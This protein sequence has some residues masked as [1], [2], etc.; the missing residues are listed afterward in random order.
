L[1]GGNNQPPSKVSSLE[2]AR[3]KNGCKKTHTQSQP[4]PTKKFQKI[5][6]NSFQPTNNIMKAATLVFLVAAAAAVLTVPAHARRLAGIGLKSAPGPAYGVF[7]GAIVP[8]P[9]Q[10]LSP[11]EVK[12]VACGNPS[13]AFLFVVLCFVCGGGMGKV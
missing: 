6:E 1:K 13:R 5:N 9:S 11:S 2:N 12:E 7:D 4:R 8:F 10:P 3:D